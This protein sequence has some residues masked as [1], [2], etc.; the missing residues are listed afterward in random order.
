M[1]LA[2]IAYL[3]SKNRTGLYNTSADLPTELNA[4]VLANNQEDLQL[5]QLANKQ[6]DRH[7]QQ[8]EQQCG[9][10]VVHSALASFERLLL[11]VQQL[12]SDYKAWYAA[13][14]L[15]GPYTYRR[16]WG[17]GYKCVQHVAHEGLGYS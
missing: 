13:H 10:G 9:Q 1:R 16:D 8:L 14:G 3:A 11:R 15:S 17:K 2:D 12:C 5:W 7:V 4:R 6:L